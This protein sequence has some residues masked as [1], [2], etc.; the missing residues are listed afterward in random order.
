MVQTIE[1]YK[2]IG[3]N[4]FDTNLENIVSVSFN[5]SRITQIVRLDDNGKIIKSKIFDDVGKSLYLVADGIIIP[6]W[7]LSVLRRRDNT[8]MNLKNN[9][10]QLQ[11]GYETGEL[12]AFQVRY[13]NG[14]YV[15]YGTNSEM[16]I[17]DYRCP[18]DAQDDKSIE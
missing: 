5:H 2:K 7:E 15:K 9:I 11:F 10:S 13:D 8:I 17:V 12:V 3:D 14:E 16:I 18:K 4:F 6:H 1:I